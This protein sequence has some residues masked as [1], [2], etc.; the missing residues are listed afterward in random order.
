MTN[1]TRGLHGH[2]QRPPLHIGAD[3]QRNKRPSCFAA[4]LV[5]LVLSLASGTAVADDCP[6]TTDLSALRTYQE[7]AARVSGGEEVPP[8][9]CA[10][11]CEEPGFVIFQEMV[12]ERLYNPFIVSNVL[13]EVYAPEETA[14]PDI[15]RK[16]A[17]RT[18][19][20]HSYSYLRDHAAEL[21]D[22]LSV[23]QSER[24]PCRAVEYLAGWLPPEVLARP[25]TLHLLPMLPEIKL[26]EDILL[27]DAGLALAAG[28]EQLVNML[29]GFLY[30]GHYATLTPLP[31]ELTGFDAMKATFD[32]LAY[33]GIAASL[34]GYL[35]LRFDHT[36]PMFKKSLSRRASDVSNS[37]E[38]M[39]RLN[40]TL[41]VLF[42][43]PETISDNG[44]IVDELLRGGSSYP[45]AGFA[46]AALIEARFSRERLR[47]CVG[48]T[49]AFLTAYQEAA[50]LKTVVAVAEIQGERPLGIEDLP[51]FD[52]E[53]FAKLIEL[54]PPAAP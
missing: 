29:A 26:L 4:V 7:L 45:T 38:T 39:L 33:E 17:K 1:I 43:N 30:R 9:A 53:M 16:R 13:R 34:E 54:F 24:I 14:T 3:G 41:K 42:K 35:D 22:F 47:A 18:D 12:T 44:N 6:I 40:S 21:E 11:L 46:M 52:E 27:V 48:S 2:N 5:P 25:L 32:R 37:N 20:V 28:P 36:H 15:P 31:H 23:L 51:Y 19:L 8:A 50:L 10:A 49:H